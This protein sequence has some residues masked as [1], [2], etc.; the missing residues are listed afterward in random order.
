M[1]TSATIG[2]NNVDSANKKRFSSPKQLTHLSPC[3]HEQ[4]IDYVLSK[5]DRRDLCSRLE[6]RHP[7]QNTTPTPLGRTR[8]ESPENAIRNFV[9]PTKD[10]KKK[11]S[12][13]S[14]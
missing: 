4:T 10:E 12:S 13:L 8:F 6:R 1:S 14:L 5:E 9:T 11:L 7:S 2:Q 3:K